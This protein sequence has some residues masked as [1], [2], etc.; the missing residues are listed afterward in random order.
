MSKNIDVEE[1]AKCINILQEIFGDASTIMSWLEY[2][3]PS[4]GNRKPRIAIVEGDA[5]E[6]VRVLKKIKNSE[7]S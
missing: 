3:H 5:E 6:V 2:P 1:F 7:L 4:L